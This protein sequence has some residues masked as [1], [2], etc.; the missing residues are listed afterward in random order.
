MHREAHFARLATLPTDVHVWAVGI[1]AGAT[2]EYREV[3][4]G[5]CLELARQP[6]E[7]DRSKLGG[8]L[9]GVLSLLSK[10]L[11]LGRFEPYLDLVLLGRGCDL[12]GQRPKGLTSVLHSLPHSGEYRAHNPEALTCHATLASLG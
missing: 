1:V 10:D 4:G 5:R 6:A 8:S 3:C 2:D 9:P 7:I 12:V 11:F